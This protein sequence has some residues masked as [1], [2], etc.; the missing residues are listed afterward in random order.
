MCTV[1][2]QSGSLRL[3]RSHPIIASRLISHGV[4]CSCPRTWLDPD[5]KRHSDFTVEVE[6][7]FFAE[8]Y[9]VTMFRLTRRT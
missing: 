1:W 2:L 7:E 3:L 9:R 6:W 8:K 4:R 5:R